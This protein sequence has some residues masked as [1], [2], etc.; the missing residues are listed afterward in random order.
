MRIPTYRVC[1][2]HKVSV[3]LQDQFHLPI[4]QSAIL[5]VCVCVCVCVCYSCNAIEELT[6]MNVMIPSGMEV[7]LSLFKYSIISAV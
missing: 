4:A 2:L 1:A 5:C 7:L 6:L 3:V